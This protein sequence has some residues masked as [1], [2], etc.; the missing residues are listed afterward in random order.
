MLG[1]TAPPEGL[2]QMTMLTPSPRR[3]VSLVP[4]TTE[5]LAELGVA[6]RVIGRTRYCVRPSPWVD[7][8]P[9]VGGTKD[10]DL[11]AIAA[12]RPDLIL[13]NTEENR[14]GQFPQ[15]AAMAPLWEGFPRD[16]DGAVSD[17]ARLAAAVGAEQAGRALLARISAAR[18]ALRA[19]ASARPPWR[20]ACLVWR[21]P[22]R[23]TGP[24]SFASAL[25]AEAGGINVVPAGTA[26]YPAFGPEELA[27]ARPDLVLLPSE[28][29]PFEAVHATELGETG[30][31][32]RLVDGQL[33]FWHGSRLAAAL[34]WLPT[35]VP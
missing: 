27:A 9:T 26:R 25:L 32:A 34:E 28:P 12:L 6:D 1:V 14:P 16:V 13:V 11:R 22:W 7:G 3:L 35:L 30:L 20:F 21:R 23:A 31:R 17:L 2:P 18:A 10:P 8:V 33:L 15:L 19:S 24:D 29:F 5:T 4:S